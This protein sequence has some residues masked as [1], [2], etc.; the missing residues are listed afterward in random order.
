MN[1]LFEQP[2]GNC[3]VDYLRKSS[4]ALILL[5]LVLS[6][7]AFGGVHAITRY[8]ITAA[9]ALTLVFWAIEL[10]LEPRRVLTRFQIPIVAL[11]SLV[12]LQL[13]PLGGLAGVLSPAGASMKAD[14]MP[15][16]VETLVDG[17]TGEIPFWTARG[18]ISV[19]PAETLRRCFWLVLMGLL[20]TRVQDLATVDTLRRLC[21]ACLINGSVLSY[22]AVLQQFTD[23]PGQIYWSYQSLGAAFGPFVNR[24]HFAFYINICFGLS[25]GLVGSRLM[26]R[27]K[28][29]KVEDLVEGLK[30]SLSLWMVSVLVFMLGA[31]ILCSS[32]GGMVS[33]FGGTLIT[34]AFI[35]ATGSFQRS[36]KWFLLAAVIFA[37]AAG[38]QTWLGFDFDD[39][40]YAMHD[41]NRTEVWWPLL[42]LVPR[43]PVT[44]TG[45]GTL[46]YV[47]PF[48]RHSNEQMDTFLEN[49]H[50]EY[51]QLLLETGIPGLL[52]GLAFIGLLT[53]K[54]AY[55]VRNSRHNAWLYVGALFGLC[56]ISLHSFVEFGFAIPAIAVLA[57]VLFGHIAGLSRIKP[58]VAMANGIPVRLFA[59]GVIVFVFFAV[60]DAKE[61]DLAVRSW[62]LGQRVL[63]NGGKPTEEL[64]HYLNA[65]AYTPDNAE[66]LLDCS[67]IQFDPARADLLEDKE[68]LYW[69]QQDLIR[70]RELCPFAAETHFLLGQ[71][72]STF[73]QADSD[74]TYYDRALK[75]RPV[76]ETLWFITG[77]TYW[78]RDDKEEAARHFQTSLALNTRH[79]DEILTMALGSMDADQVARSILPRGNSEPLMAAAEWFEKRSQI[80]DVVDANQI[81]L[82]NN[83]A[84]QSRQWALE[85]PE[86]LAPDSGELHCRKARLLILLEQPA[87]A[88]SSYKLAL[89]YEPKRI[90]WRLELATVLG[91]QGQY[92]E[93]HRQIKRVLQSRPGLKAAERLGVALSKQQAADG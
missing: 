32:R 49:A 56:T 35:A 90:H 37:I 87:K 2:L 9:I 14:M 78:D 65:L 28:S 85:A 79:L 4:E 16:Q 42:Q 81:E 33:L 74:L 13:L 31:V 59:V 54:I 80:V 63:Q 89:N 44:G 50:N 21:F 7:W 57:A 93:A 52:C 70:V 27:V 72:A 5:V 76:D 58:D 19:Y 45:L 12:C 29:F 86:L 15:A 25:L 3:V 1:S 69:A 75:P 68:V 73:A 48:T 26:G 18:R 46:A 67:R 23:E 64:Q 8:V 43:F 53:T 77:K 84:L 39:S 20:V 71:S 83:A 82:L 36:W 61:Y 91:E 66:F 24:N 88:I 51:L 10:L 30:D 17:S 34:A 38:V 47:E 22:F 40:R 41:D 92:D 6:P 60:R 62:R 11:V 55:R